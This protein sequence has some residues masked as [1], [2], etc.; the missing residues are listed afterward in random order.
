[1]ALLELKLQGD[2]AWEDWKD[3]PE[4]PLDPNRP[5]RIA[6]MKAGTI[7]G[8]DSIMIGAEL[9]DGSVV[10]LQ[11]TKD[12]FLAAAAAIKAAP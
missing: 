10:V 3:K 12:L 7:S 1:M 8:K 11:T 9:D 4:N 5:I 6:R 2:K